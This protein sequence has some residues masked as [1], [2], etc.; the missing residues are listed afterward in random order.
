MPTRRPL[1]DR[2]YSLGLAGHDQVNRAFG[3]GL[4]KGS[5]VL[6]EGSYGT[7]KSTLAGRFAHGLCE[8]GHD[9]SYL[10][11]EQPVGRFVDQMQ[12]LSYDVTGALL[13][14]DL[15]FMFGD[16]AAIDARTEEPPP[17]LSRLTATERMWKNDVVVLDT[18]GDI[19][20]YDPT[21]ELLAETHDRRRAAQRVLSFFRRVTARGCTVVLT[22][23]TVG[24][25]D[26]ALQPFRSVA[27][28][29]L[30]LTQT[31]G[32]SAGRRTIE[33]D[34]F[35]G[36]GQVVDDRIGFAIRPGIGIVIQN[37][38]VI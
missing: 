21:F 3:G 37:R 2:C 5:I 22:A 26:E 30:R 19:L 28:V 25:P 29:V 13:A 11:T 7:G 16:L 9:V 6:V 35:R 1:L 32:G 38:R 31:G 15:L 8:S 10:S 18:F 24:L 23:D 34:R 36:A 4:P 27:D 14:R 17:L 20:R 12:T 33:V